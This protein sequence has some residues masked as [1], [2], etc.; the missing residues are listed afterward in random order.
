MPV[1]HRR[2]VSRAGREWL[3]VAKGA[4][5]S[6]PFA[7]LQFLG[8]GGPHTLGGP[9]DGDQFLLRQAFTAGNPHQWS[10]SQRSQYTTP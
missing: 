2:L 9:F 10:D 8:P 1:A 7:L 3:R 4:G 6:A 5:G